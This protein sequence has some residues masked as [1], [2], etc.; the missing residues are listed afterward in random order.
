MTQFS[1]PTAVRLALYVGYRPSG[2]KCLEGELAKDGTGGTGPKITLVSEKGIDASEDE[3]L[4]RE[5]VVVEP[6]LR[7]RNLKENYYGK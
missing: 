5:P 1:R 4:K 3:Y 7:I 6:I 2:R